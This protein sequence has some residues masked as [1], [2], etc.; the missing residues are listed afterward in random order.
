MPRLTPRCGCVLTAG[1]SLAPPADAAQPGTD[2][3]RRVW[4][5]QGEPHTTG[6]ASRPPPGWPQVTY[7]GR[8]G[9]AQIA[10]S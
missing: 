6:K 7:P 5:T 1:P 10:T 2:R 8:G 3:P 9:G 4:N